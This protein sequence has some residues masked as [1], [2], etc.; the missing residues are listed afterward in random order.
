M[1]KHLYDL[2]FKS[3]D[4]VYKWL[5]EKSKVPLSE[6]RNRSW[7]DESTNGWLGIEGTSGKHW[8]ELPDDYMVPMMSSPS[9][10]CIIIGG[11]E[12]EVCLQIG[13]GRYIPS[14][15]ELDRWGATAYSVDA[16]R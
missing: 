1:A 15:H 8:K 2:G 14:P 16:W 11:G 13:G 4:D 9:Q 10:N 7:P 12:E 5:Y 6:Y 3:K